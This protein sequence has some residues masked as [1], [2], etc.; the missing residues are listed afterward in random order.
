MSYD[1]GV[2]HR[3][4]IRL[5]GYDY[6]QQG[7]YFVTV[8]TQER[9]CVL[10]DVDGGKAILRGVGQ[11]VQEKWHD[12]VERFPGIGLGAFVAM[13]NHIHGIV[14]IRMAGADGPPLGEIMRTFRAAS[15][16][17][18]RQAAMPAFAWQRG[19]RER[20]IRN[21][22]EYDATERYIVYNP[23]SWGEDE[24][25]PDAALPGSAK[26]IGY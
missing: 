18:I 26:G 16:H 15:T 24:E 9:Q 11:I 13:P 19:Y 8:C 14:I 7:A 22:A 5:K 17:H 3:R 12:L 4:S 23:R 6:S 21:Q 2:H 1:P 25:N 10:G 20:V